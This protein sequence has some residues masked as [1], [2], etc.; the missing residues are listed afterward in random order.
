M[1]FFK[2]FKSQF[3]IEMSASETAFNFTVPIDRFLTILPLTL[4]PTQII[5]CRR[6]GLLKFKIPRIPEVPA[7]RIQCE[8]VKPQELK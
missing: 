2:V 4:P 3:T 8:R 7:E 5:I 1:N 6:S